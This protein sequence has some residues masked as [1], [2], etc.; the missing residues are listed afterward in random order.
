MIARQL[1]SSFA[2]PR[3]HSSI[4]TKSKTYEIRKRR[5]EL[6][7]PHMM[8]LCKRN[9]CLELNM[10]KCVMVFLA[11]MLFCC[12]NSVCMAFHLNEESNSIYPKVK[13]MPSSS[14]FSHKRYSKTIEVFYQTG[15]SFNN[16]L[17]LYI[18]HMFH[19]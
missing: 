15:V 5:I 14:S 10:S 4:T 12:C 8:S 1:L 17:H 11:L 6:I 2:P 13:L 18:V 16:L 19:K 3:W 7:N 9:N